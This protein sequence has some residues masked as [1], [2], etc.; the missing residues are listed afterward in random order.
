LAQAVAAYLSDLDS[1]L[2]RRVAQRAMADPD[3]SVRATAARA[4]GW[5]SGFSDVYLALT[6]LRGDPEM[7]VRI[8]AIEALSPRL[9]VPE[10]AGEIA[11]FLSDPE[12]R[13][14]EAAIRA[15][16]NRRLWPGS[17]GLLVPAVFDPA[18]P[19]R[20]IARA[21]VPE[22]EVVAWLSSLARKVSEG[23]P[24]DLSELAALARADQIEDDLKGRAFVERLE[25]LRARGA[26]GLADLADTIRALSYWM[27]DLPPGLWR[28][29]AAEPAVLDLP[30]DLLASVLRKA[31]SAAAWVLFRAVLSRPAPAGGLS[32]RTGIAEYAGKLGKDVPEI[33]AGLEEL[34]R[35]EAIEREARR[36]AVWAFTKARPEPAALRSLEDIALWAQDEKV[37]LTA[38]QAIETAFPTED[39]IP[40]MRRISDA[41]S[42]PAV[43]RRAVEYLTPQGKE[44]GTVVDLSTR[45]RRPPRPDKVDV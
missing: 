16:V 42:T 40:V 35:D 5:L 25:A 43:R 9:E 20:K 45:R 18:D 21:V 12:W 23:K 19:V 15:F 6:A 3:P 37:A 14:R 1:K 26:A 4:A 7:Q 13:V 8:A 30:E 24:V 36:S 31:R 38:I 34:A 11:E 32:L 2:A 44:G 29:L 10:V 28:A 33:L 41:A 39:A 22:D 17:A 27:G